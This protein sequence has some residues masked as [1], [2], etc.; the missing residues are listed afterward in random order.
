MASLKL[1]NEVLESIL[2]NK[3]PVELQ[4]EVKEITTDGSVKKF[5]HK[6]L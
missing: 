4:K 3:V 1:T 5:L 6:L 2:L